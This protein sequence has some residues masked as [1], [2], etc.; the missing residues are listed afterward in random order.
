RREFHLTSQASAPRST[1]VFSS[2]RSHYRDASHVCRRFP[3]ALIIR[4]SSAFVKHTLGA[5]SRHF[6]TLYSTFSHCGFTPTRRG[7]INHAPTGKV[8]ENVLPCPGVLSAM[9]RPPWA[10]ITCRAIA[11]PRPLPPPP[12]PIKS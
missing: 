4:F 11:R 2:R 1:S 3:R 9:I 6:H 8:K 5:V 10:S 7:V 12:G